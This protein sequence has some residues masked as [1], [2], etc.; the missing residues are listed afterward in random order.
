[1]GR[2]IAI[3]TFWASSASNKAAHNSS[4][5]IVTVFSGA[6]RVLAQSKWEDMTLEESMDRLYIHAPYAN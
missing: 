4:R 3:S 5:G 6:T 1:M 2:S